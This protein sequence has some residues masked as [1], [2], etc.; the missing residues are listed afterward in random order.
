MKG[1][2]G[3]RARHATFITSTDR[4]ASVALLLKSHRLLMLAKRK[5]SPAPYEIVI[6]VSIYQQFDTHC[7]TTVSGQHNLLAGMP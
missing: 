4:F 2:H 7:Y 1:Q 6:L 5:L 3:H